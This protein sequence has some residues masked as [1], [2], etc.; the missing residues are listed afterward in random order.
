[1]SPLSGAVES[2][3]PVSKLHALESFDPEDFPVPRGREE[4]WR[5]TPF[6]G[7]GR[8][9]ADCFVRRKS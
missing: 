3:G 9:H 1:M 8:L 4:E 5:F 2:A 6:A 7:C